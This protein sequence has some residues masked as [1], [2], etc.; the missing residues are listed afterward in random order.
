MNNLLEN[1]FL[2]SSIIGILI[3]LAMMAQIFTQKKANFFMGL[4]VFIIA[5]ELLFSWGAKSGYTNMPGAFPY[6]FLL[7]YLILPPSIWLFVKYNTD[8]NFKFQSWHYF[9]YFPAFLAYT[10]D[11]WSRNSA[12][13]LINYPLWIFFTD[14]LPL[15]GT[16]YAI[17]FFWVKYFQYTPFK[18]APKAIFSQLR[19]V[20]LML[21]LSLVCLFWLIFSFVG[22][23]NYEWIEFTM[24]FLFIGFAFLHFLDNQGL[25][26][27]AL[28]EKNKEFPNYD[29]QNSL[30]Q[31][32]QQLKE[33]QYFLKPNL[34][35][36]ELAAELELPS[37]Y[38]SF[39]INH[40]HHK[41]YKEFINQYRI[42]AFLNKA[43]SSE[44]DSKTLLGLAL[45]SG[46]SSKST[47][48]QVFKKQMGKSPSEYLN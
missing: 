47:F 20:I 35:L 15:I 42:E 13:S 6:W 21:S 25:P 4:V 11:L 41:N 43:Q 7:N 2:V 5:I 10:M 16:V 38:V 33:H 28:K 18:S 39:L 46:F 24:T 30:Q 22:W 3:S 14:Y 19:L 36:K 12:L 1:L 29:D 26:T 40:Y 23:E 32:E 17:G 31:I 44:K 27:L 48:N 34:P 37:R 8:D 9:L 45:E